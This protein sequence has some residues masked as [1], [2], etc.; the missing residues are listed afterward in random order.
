MTAETGA[1]AN[2]FVP[3]NAMVVP[4]QHYNALLAMAAVVRDALG[5]AGN[6]EPVGIVDLAIHHG[7][8]SEQ[9]GDTVVVDQAAADIWDHMNAVESALAAETEVEIK[10]AVPA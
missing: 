9:D 7:V 2:P 10:E 6:A 1:P 3:I 4:V 8:L 5:D